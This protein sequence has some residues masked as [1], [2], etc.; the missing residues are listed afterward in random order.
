MLLSYCSFRFLLVQR[1]ILPHDVR[2]TSIVVLYLP[3][4]LLDDGCLKSKVFSGCSITD[5]T[6]VLLRRLS[7]N[8]KY[9][10]Y[11]GWQLLAIT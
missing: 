10:L 11:R 6:P 4:L 2:V 7:R 3:C 8:W 5:I 1:T 9:G